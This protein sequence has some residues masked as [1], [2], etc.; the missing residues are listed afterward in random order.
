MD[1]VLR[2]AY[3]V[4]RDLYLCSFA[5]GRAVNE[6]GNELNEFSLP[7]PAPIKRRSGGLRADECGPSPPPA[8][9]SAPLNPHP[10]FPEAVL[11]FRPHI[12]SPDTALSG[13]GYCTPGPSGAPRLRVPY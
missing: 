6:L 12:Y 2:I 4:L 1:C 11:W 7:I 10:V 3:C 9:K 13:P 5:F 8:G